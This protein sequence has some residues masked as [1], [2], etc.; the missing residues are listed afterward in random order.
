MDHCAAALDGTVD[1]ARLSQ[2]GDVVACF[3]EEHAMYSRSELWAS[4]KMMW[5]LMHEAGQGLRHLEKSGKEPSGLADA[6]KTADLDLAA[7]GG[8]DSEVDYYFEIPLVLAK[9][10]TGF[11]HDEIID[12]DVQFEVLNPTHPRWNAKET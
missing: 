1:L 6:I 11:K 5:S 10:L 12:G 9:A 7:N 2:L 3:V 4:G 8:D